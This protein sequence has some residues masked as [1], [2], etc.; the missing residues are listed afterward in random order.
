MAYSQER[1]PLGVNLGPPANLLTNQGVRDQ[2][3]RPHRKGAAHDRDLTRD[4]TITNWA[5]KQL[6]GVQVELHH[7]IPES[8]KATELENFGSSSNACSLY[9][10]GL[11]PRGCLS[12]LGR[13]GGREEEPLRVPPLHLLATCAMHRAGACPT[14][15]LAGTNR[16]AQSCTG[17]R[18]K[19]MYMYVTVSA[20]THPRVQVR[21]SVHTYVCAHLLA[22]A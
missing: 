9:C 6:Q 14:R 15:A 3:L 13:G 8:R 19:N 20:Q 1:S 10:I 16:G 11:I 22:L 4:Q 12:A 17:K 7:A 2:S 18:P 21:V 5:R